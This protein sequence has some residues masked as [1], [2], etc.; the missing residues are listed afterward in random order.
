MK[1]EGIDKIAISTT[2]FLVESNH[3]LTIYPSP[4]KPNDPEQKEEPILFGNQKGKKAVFNSKSFN[5][6]INQHRLYLHFNPSKLLHPYNLTNDDNEIQQVWDFIRE[7]IKEAGILLPP[8]NELKLSRV[9]LAINQQM[10]HPNSMYFFLWRTLRGKYMNTKEYPD[11]YN[12]GNESR[13]ISFYDKTEEVNQRNQDI[14]IDP[15]LMRSELR[16]FSGEVVKNIYKLNDLSTLLKMG[17]EYRIEKFKNTLNTTI[18]SSGDREGQLQMFVCDRDREVE[19]LRQLKEANPRGGIEEWMRN[20]GLEAK[21]QSLGSMEILFE[22]LGEAG[23][24]REYT[25]RKIRQFEQSR[26]K[27]SFYQ[28]ENKNTNVTKLYNEV[29]TKFAV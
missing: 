11:S 24:Q 13:E 4:Y 1:S 3:H 14:P 22:V 20:D 6:D 9:D 29:Y 15:K 18:F 2:D 8:D 12:F 16:A 19:I 28:T 5:L 17:G 10:N 25:Y 23:Y 7:E 21:L 27:S 26:R